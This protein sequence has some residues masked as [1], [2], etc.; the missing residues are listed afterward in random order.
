MH[1][2][3][4]RQPVPSRQDIVWPG[5]SHVPPQG[6]PEKFHLTIGFLEV[7]LLYLV[8]IFTIQFH[9]ILVKK[10]LFYFYSVAVLSAYEVS[11]CSVFF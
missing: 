1:I 6:V 7:P 9:Y 2:V 8:P 11:L 3:Y 4:T 10:F 5:E